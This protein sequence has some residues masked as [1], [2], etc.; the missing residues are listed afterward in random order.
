MQ[1]QDQIVGS[2]TL[3]IPAIQSANFVSGSSGWA[4]FQNGNAEFN[5]ATF[6]GT[7]IVEGGS[8][9]ILIYSGTPAAGNLIVSIAGAA[10]SD[11]FG[12]HYP[13]GFALNPAGTNT[14]AIE[15]TILAGSPV[16]FFPSG[17]TKENN[18]AAFQLTT[19]G[20]GTAAW[21]QLTL[22]SANMVD[23]TDYSAIT[24]SSSS[25]DGVSNH[26]S[27]GL[28]YVDTSGTPHVGLQ[29]ANG[30][31]TAPQGLSITGAGNGLKVAEGSNAKQG[32]AVLVAGTVVV[33]STSVTANSRI[34]LTS[35]VDGGTPGFL[36][37]STRTA[38]TS[39]TIKSGSATD[40]STVAYEI[41]EPA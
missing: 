2:T 34:F 8:Q 26:A 30:L 24:L 9:A 25:D 20:S 27:V 23:T 31:T 1:P 41:I 36:R 29:V 38:G 4:I 28:V 12:N 15:L 7:V 22:K 17:L 32:T 3:R 6:R 16:Q 10:G 13:Q 40:T 39:F 21:A 19:F 11:T 33:S 37:V 35:Q 18:A 14:P 5:G